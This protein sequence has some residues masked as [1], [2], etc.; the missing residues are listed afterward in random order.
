MLYFNT[1]LKN[2]NSTLMRKRKRLSHCISLILTFIKIEKEQ[3]G[4]YLLLVNFEYIK[5]LID[6]NGKV[7]FQIHAGHASLN[8]YKD[9]PKNQMQGTKARETKR[10]KSTC[11]GTFQY[12]RRGKNDR[13]MLYV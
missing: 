1:I 3:L 4:I 13:N 6:I 12:G 8:K 11:N 2:P 5:I 7:I 9:M 10:E